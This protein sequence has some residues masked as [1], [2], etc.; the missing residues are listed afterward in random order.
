MS[1]Q[2]YQR[3]VSSLLRLVAVL[4]LFQELRVYKKALN[5]Y[6]NYMN[7][8][9]DKKCSKMYQL[10]NSTSAMVYQYSNYIELKQE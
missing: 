2:A 1:S 7:N 8:I 6:I 4:L 5:K 3:T 10:T 9:I